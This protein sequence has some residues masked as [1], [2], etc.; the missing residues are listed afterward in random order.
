MGLLKW[1]VYSNAP[2]TIFLGKWKY[3]FKKVGFQP[4]NATNRTWQNRFLL[5][6]N[7]RFSYVGF[8]LIFFGLPFASSSCRSNA[9]ITI[10]GRL[11]VDRRLH[12]R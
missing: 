6:S 9:R 10:R 12:N 3:D 4:A 2:A 5:L 7:P 8:Y 11:D 1:V